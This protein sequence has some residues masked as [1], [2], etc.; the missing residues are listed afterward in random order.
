M[1]I[2]NVKKARENI[3]DVIVKTPIL[4]SKVF[5]DISNNTVYMKCE[6][7]QLTGAYRRA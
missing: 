2:E 1:Y 3:K 7:L 4:H 5:S 6:N